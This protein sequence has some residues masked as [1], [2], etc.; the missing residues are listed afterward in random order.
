MLYLLSV[1]FAERGHD[2]A[3]E[4]AGERHEAGHGH[5]LRREHHPH[6]A[7]DGDA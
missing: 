7:P 6:A 4:E 5:E 1:E 3:Q 2:E